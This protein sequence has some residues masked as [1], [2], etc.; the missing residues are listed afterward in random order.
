MVFPMTMWPGVPVFKQATLPAVYHQPWKLRFRWRCRVDCIRGM[1]CFMFHPM[2]MVSTCPSLIN[3][4]LGRNMS[5]QTCVNISYHAFFV[6][7]EGHLFLPDLLTHQRWCI[8]NTNLFILGTGTSLANPRI[9]QTSG[10]IQVPF[11]SSP[12]KILLCFLN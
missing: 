10:I 1:V 7:S 4:F 6:F 12:G 5:G 2:F 8:Y 3:N 9:D 11:F